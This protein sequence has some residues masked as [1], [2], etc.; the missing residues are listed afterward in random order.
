MVNFQFL[1][2]FHL[3]QYIFSIFYLFIF[4]LSFECLARVFYICKCNIT[5]YNMPR[6]HLISWCVSF[7]DSFER[8]AENVRL[9]KISLL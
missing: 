4:S 9:Y 6:F 5:L 3:L 7:V 8:F 2:C 1:G